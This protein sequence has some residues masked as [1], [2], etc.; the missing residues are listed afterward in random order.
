MI[1]IPFLDETASNAEKA[2]NQVPSRDLS[3]VPG[4]PSKGKKPWKK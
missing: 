3:G 2:D 1:S 4:K